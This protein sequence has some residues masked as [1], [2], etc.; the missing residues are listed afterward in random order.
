VHLPLDALA[1][2]LREDGEATVVT[3]R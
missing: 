1:R 2:L 3:D